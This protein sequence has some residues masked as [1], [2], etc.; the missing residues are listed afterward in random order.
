MFAQAIETILRDHCTPADVRHIEAGGSPQPL[1]QTLERAGFLELLTPED[2]GGAGIQLPELHPVLEQLGRHAMP[3]PAAQ[4]IVVRALLPV[5]TAPGG[6]LSIAPHL[7]RLD[8]GGFDCPRVP[9]GGMADHVL[10]AD[11]QGWVLLDATIAKRNQGDIPGLQMTS[12]SWQDDAAVVRSGRGDA[13]GLESFGA[14]L[15]A[16]LITGAMGRVFEMTLQH[17]ND[18]TQ[19]GRS[20][21]QFQAV[22]HQ[23]AVMAEHIAAAS[24]ATQ[25][26]FSS[27]GFSPDPMAAAMAKARASAAAALVA[28]TAHALHGAIGVTAE[29][30]LQLLTRRL[31]AWRIAHG[32]ESFWHRRI[33]AAVLASDR[34]L[35]AFVRGA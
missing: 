16:A 5:G 7:T 24:S 12:L 23:L 26:A 10:A 14:A 2:Q 29:Y 6:L 19:F 18:R 3:V 13:V 1:W 15:H 31:H 32:S 11:S 20:L 21:G 22:Q 8:D 33:G 4:A 17:C 35:T 9:Y 34:P 30:D 28:A 25:L 27:D